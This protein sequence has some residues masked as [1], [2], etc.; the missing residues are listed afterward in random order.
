VEIKS[1]TRWQGVDAAGTPA[2]V[3]VRLRRRNC[4]LPPI[5]AVASRLLTLLAKEHV[6]LAEVSATIA[7]DPAVATEVLRS[8]NSAYYG[9]RGEVTELQH[10]ATLLGLDRIRALAA[11]IGLRR[12]LGATL[13]APAVRRSWR[14]NLACALTAEQL[15]KRC[16]GHRGDAYTAGLLHDLGRLAL[17]VAHPMAYPSFLDTTRAT[18]RQLLAEERELFTMD[19]C[20]AGRWLAEQ[21]LLPRAFQDVAEHHHDPAAVGPTG[22]LVRVGVACRLADHLGHWVVAPPD[23]AGD[24]VAAAA[25]LDLI[26]LPLPL[27]QRATLASEIEALGEDVA[28]DVGALD[29]LL[30]A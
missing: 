17:I 26:L 16:G 5:P 1:Q 6:G 24:P 11:T 23:T 8:A 21:L 22:L 9:I 4:E 7:V 27:A 2:P 14:H 3:T 19:H 25:A 20:E 28:R 18:G 29:D 15:A 12:Y 13:K 30:G 10:A